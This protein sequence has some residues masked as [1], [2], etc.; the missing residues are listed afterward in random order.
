MQTELTCTCYFLSLCPIRNQYA[1]E[2][3]IFGNLALP[4][5]Q[6][7]TGFLWTCTA[8]YEFADLNGWNLI[9]LMRL[10]MHPWKL[11]CETIWYSNWTQRDKNWNVYDSQTWE[12]EKN[13]Q[14]R[15]THQTVNINLKLKTMKTNWNHIPRTTRMCILHQIKNNVQSTVHNNGFRM[16]RDKGLKVSEASCPLTWL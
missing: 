10:F 3:L 12:K 7:R 6:R 11:H 1:V 9:Q 13:W 15:F 14:I 4:C 16:T 2:V 5:Y 8:V